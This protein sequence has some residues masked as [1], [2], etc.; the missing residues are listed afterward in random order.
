MTLV[1]LVRAPRRKPRLPDSNFHSVAHVS[2]NMTTPWLVLLHM[3]LCVFCMH[4]DEFV[5]SDG[6]VNQSLVSASLFA[7]WLPV[8]ATLAFRPRRRTHAKSVGL[9]SSPQ[10]AA[11]KA[12]DCPVAAMPWRSV[13]RPIPL[14]INRILLMAVSKS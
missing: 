6:N 1:E 2:S 5:R 7:P 8:P 14:R 10:P 9:I 13:A 3:L 4:F 12:H 11:A